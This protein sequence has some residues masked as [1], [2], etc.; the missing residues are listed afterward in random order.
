[1][2]EEPAHLPINMNGG[3]VHEREHH[4]VSIYEYNRRECLTANYLQ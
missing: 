2:S 3:S 1:M 4:R